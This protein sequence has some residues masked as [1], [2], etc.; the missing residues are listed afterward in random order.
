M[1]TN[2]NN[3]INTVNKHFKYHNNASYIFD[4]DSND[5]D[6]SN[7]ENNN[8]ANNN[9]DNSNENNKLSQNEITGKSSVTNTTDYSGFHT[10]THDVYTRTRNPFLCVN[11]ATAASYSNYY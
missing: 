9:N 4:A 7:D 10:I 2:R 1:Q 6:D 8:T 3:N 5:N 11:E